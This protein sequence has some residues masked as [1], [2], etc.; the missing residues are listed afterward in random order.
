MLHGAYNRH[1]TEVP[2]EPTGVLRV[3]N[4]A[5][6]TVGY[7]AWDDTKIAYMAEIKNRW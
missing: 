1:P 5:S 6:T 7:I 2:E 4:S 3:K